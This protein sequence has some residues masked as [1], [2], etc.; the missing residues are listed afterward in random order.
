MNTNHFYSF[1][2][3]IHYYTA[4]RDQEIFT[5]DSPLTVWYNTLT[6]KYFRN[7]IKSVYY[8]YISHPKNT[9]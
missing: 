3:I 1:I 4:N 7:V 8:L 9:I 2:L 5:T 6:S